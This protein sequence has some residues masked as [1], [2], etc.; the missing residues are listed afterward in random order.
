MSTKRFTI[1]LT[2][3]VDL[4]GWREEYGSDETTAQIVESLRYSI[5]DAA[6]ISVAHLS[7]VEVTA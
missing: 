4:D 5:T 3:T 1:K 6:Q 2:V 7:C